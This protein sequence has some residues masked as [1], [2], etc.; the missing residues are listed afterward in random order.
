MVNDFLCLAFAIYFEARNQ[1]VDGQIAVAE[2]IIRRAKSNNYPNNLCDVV[3]QYKQ[4]SF[5]W[6]GLPEVIND[7]KA[8]EKAKDS[9]FKAIVNY[10]SVTKC[11]THYHNISIKPKWARKM[12]ID[13]TIKDH[14]FLCA[15]VAEMVRR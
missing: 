14:V 9:A 8:F 2:V 6:D 1:P 15:G 4:F 3:K 11:A 7:N 13:K 10:P 5:Y 12:Y